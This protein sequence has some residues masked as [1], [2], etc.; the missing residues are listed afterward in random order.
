MTIKKAKTK[1]ITYVNRNEL[2]DG[3][4]SERPGIGDRVWS[5]INDTR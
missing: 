1:T 2:F 4:E 3:L 5:H